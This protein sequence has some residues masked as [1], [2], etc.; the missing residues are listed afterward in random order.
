MPKTCCSWCKST[1]KPLQQVIINRYSHDDFDYE[2]F[3]KDCLNPD[4]SLPVAE[5]Y[6]YAWELEDYGNFSF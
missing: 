6:G 1:K 2:Y 5:A 4:D 3:C